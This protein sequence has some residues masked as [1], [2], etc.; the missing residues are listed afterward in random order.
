MPTA[1]PDAP[2]VPAPAAGRAESASPSPASTKATQQTRPYFYGQGSLLVDRDRQVAGDVPWLVAGISH[3]PLDWFRLAASLELESLRMFG[4]QQLFVE[5]APHPAFGAR[6]GLLV[7]PL[8][9][10]NRA[11]DPVG[12][13]SVERPFTDRLVLPTT[14]RELGAGIFGALGEDVRYEVLVASGLDAAGFSA[15]APLWGGRGNGRSLAIHDA[16]VVARLELGRASTGFTMGGGGYWG[17]ATGGRAELEG[18]RVAVA[19]ADARYHAFGL[20]LRAQFAEVFIVNSYRVNDYLGL[21]GQDAVPAAGRGVYAQA[22]LDVLNVGES[23]ADLPGRQRLVLFAGFENVNP[24]SRMSQYNFNPAT[25][26]PPG[27]V[28]PNAP[29]PSRSFVRGG[30]SYHPWSV[31]AIKI[32]VQVALNAEAP[33]ATAPMTVMGAPGTPTALPSYLTDAARGRTR[34]GLALAWTF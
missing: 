31:V 21:L 2:A 22:G 29:S 12:F 27:E 5:V 19:E 6:A 15:S 9:I 16:A 1:G 7:M 23:A 30:V 28:P 3:R 11:N 33:P 18:V 25:I 8:G 32:D 34:L 13:P 26:T 24:R 4:V 14:W 20:D 17:G 10:M